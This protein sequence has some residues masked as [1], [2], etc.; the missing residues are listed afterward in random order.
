MGLP[1]DSLV[2]TWKVVKCRLQQSYKY[3]PDEFI[4]AVAPKVRSGRAWNAE[5]VLEEAERDLVC[6]SMLGMV[7]PGKRAGI[8]FG[9]WKKPWEKMNFEERRKAALAWSGCR[10]ISRKKELWSM[11]VWSFKVVG[12]DGGRMF[13]RLICHG[14]RFLRWAI[15]WLDSL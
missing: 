4:R 14:T 3:S 2:D 13:C 11:V 6:E 8:G 9:E 12:P 1:I 15:P 5:E 7:Q 10:K